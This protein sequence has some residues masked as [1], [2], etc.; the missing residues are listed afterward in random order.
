MCTIELKIQ[1]QFVCGILLKKGANE[2]SEE[3]KSKLLKDKYVQQLIS[4]KF[5]TAENEVVDNTTV[6][7]EVVKSR[8]RPRKISI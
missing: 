6:E 2:I 1:D 3:D 8:G 4:N 7:D 5:L